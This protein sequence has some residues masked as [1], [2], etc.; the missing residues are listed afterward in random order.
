MVV[1]IW[2]INFI[3][4]ISAVNIMDPN[5]PKGEIMKDKISCIL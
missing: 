4:F 5:S 3:I 1:K 2:Y